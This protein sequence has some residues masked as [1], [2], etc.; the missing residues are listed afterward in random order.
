[1]VE[2]LG[3]L[4]VHNLSRWDK[5]IHGFGWEEV[6]ISFCLFHSYKQIFPHLEARRYFPKFLIVFTNTLG[7]LWLFIL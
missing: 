5:R 7:N 6:G 3:C 4:L 2:D 1:M